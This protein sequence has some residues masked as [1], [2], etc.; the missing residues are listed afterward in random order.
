M[1]LRRLPELVATRPACDVA[2]EIAPK[3]LAAWNPNVVA[4][5]ADETVISIL[6]Q[7]GESY[8]GSGVTAKAVGNVLQAAN[9]RPVTVIMN[10]PGGNFFEGLA[11]YNMLRAH[12]A[13]VTVQIVGI[14]ASAA[15]VIA[16]AGDA[17]E[18]ARA[19]MLMIHNTQWVAV[20]DRHAMQEAHDTMAV[21]DEAAVNLYVD[22]TAE[23]PEDIAK[24]MDA[25]TFISSAKALE[26]GFATD[27]L[28]ADK[29]PTAVRASVDDRSPV[30]RLDMALARL[31]MSRTERRKL[32]KDFTESM[33]G[34]ALQTATPGAG[35]H[36]VDDG[37]IGLSL[38][39]ARLKLMGA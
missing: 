17:I 34:A 31:G 2:F 11:I 19:G 27:L 35:D 18:I 5:A 24:M 30:Y 21:F 25:T 14:A 16:M 6:D 33:P 12:P 38:A 22:R 1:S 20:G 13:M 36:A 23:K 15:S 7:I 39:L 32:I 37:A 9:G 28:E 10:S 29:T 8:D 4:A 26:M 3:A